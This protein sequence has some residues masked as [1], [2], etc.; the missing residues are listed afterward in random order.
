MYK[1]SLS[2][3]FKKYFDIDKLCDFIW[4]ENVFPYVM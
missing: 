4:E 3:E 1:V 2:C